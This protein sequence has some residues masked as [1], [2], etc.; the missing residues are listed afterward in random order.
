MPISLN[1]NL[2]GDS[3]SCNKGLCANP[4]AGCL[5][6]LSK[7]L[8]IGLIN[9]LPD[10]ALEATE[11]QFLSLLEAASEGFSITLSLY[12]LPGVPRGE[13]AERYV[14]TCYASAE[15]L[16][17]TTLDGLIVT[18]REPLTPNLRD[19]PYWD[20][21][22]RVLEWA[23]TNTYSTVWSCLAAHAAILHMDGIGRI[24]NSNKHCG[25]FECEQISHHALTAGTPSLFRLPHSRWNGLSEDAL[26]ACGYQVLTQCA[27][28]GVDTF[29]KQQNSLFVYFQGHPEYESHTLLLEY[30][31]DVGRYL[32]GETDTYPLLPRN[33]F[34][35]QTAAALAGLQQKAISCRREE[36]LAEVSNVLA[37]TSIEN[38]WRTT[39][40]G[41]YKN[42]LQYIAAQKKLQFQSCLATADAPA[43]A[44]A[45][46][47]A[48]V[49]GHTQH[50][51]TAL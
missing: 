27:D 18:G 8:H 6:R 20:S 50:F 36:L 21:F 40:A 10:G 31:R 33:Y 49:N 34:D 48:M 5:E 35:W 51:Q 45:D 43:P 30:R 46:S 14:R 15:S 23:Q 42:W 37:E 44:S 28:A 41:I 29:V 22:T 2:P 24:R 17:G 38:T 11:R 4:S 47:F 12:A 9:N 39:A 16:W 26:T 1:S 13:A 32:R 7:R 3:K 19:E 25:I